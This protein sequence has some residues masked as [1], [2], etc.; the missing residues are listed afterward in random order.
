[1]ALQANGTW[2]ATIVEADLNWT[3]ST[4]TEP[5]HHEIRGVAGPE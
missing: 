1:M 3:A 4:D 2:N 5:D